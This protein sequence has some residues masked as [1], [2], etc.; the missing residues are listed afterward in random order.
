[1][2]ETELETERADM[3]KSVQGR[4]DS[5][6][7]GAGHRV[8]RLLRLKGVPLA[9]T[10]LTQTLTLPCGVSGPPTGIL[11]ALESELSACLVPL[12]RAAWLALF[13]L[14]INLAHFYEFSSEPCKCTIR[15]VKSP[16]GPSE[17]HC[18][19]MLF[20]IFLCLP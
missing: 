14:L 4:G 5:P 9:Q 13:F 17:N 18:L 16:A 19:S 11:V 20:R 6:E 3:K 7:S 12:G 1:M 15:R 2:L 10:V 8:G